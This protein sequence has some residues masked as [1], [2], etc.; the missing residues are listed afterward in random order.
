MPNQTQLNLS[1][2]KA[3]L[4]FIGRGND[5]PGTEVLP[6]LTGLAA[7]TIA[8]DKTLRGRVAQSRFTEILLRTLTTRF[9]VQNRAVDEQQ[10][11]RMISSA[12]R[13]QHL[14]IKDQT[15]YIP[16]HLESVPSDE[17]IELGPVTFHPLAAF[18]TTDRAQKKDVAAWI[19]QADLIAEITV[20][21]CEPVMSRRR[22]E[23]AVARARDMIRLLSAEA[24][25]MPVSPDA[26][27]SLPSWTMVTGAVPAGLLEQAGNSLRCLV[28]PDAVWPLAERFLDAVGWY[29]MAARE[30]AEAAAITLWVNALERLTMTR[31][32]ERITDCVARRTALL[33]MR[34][35]E[36]LGYEAGRTM[37][38]NLYMVRCGLVHGALRPFD[39]S[40]P[41]ERIEAERITRMSLLGSLAFFGEV[42]LLSTRTTIKKLEDAYDAMEKRLQSR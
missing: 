28:E 6:L 8:S 11:A 16:V 15:H 21:A 22:A 36:A 9:V 31:D 14:S 37:A 7:R 13:F 40:L 30:P 1:D 12:T 23:Q 19:G 29:A 25:L 4:S 20:P 33:V 35:D 10:V 34:A 39:A 41:G 27:H 42:G 2:V 17:T 38:D 3:A 26:A 5:K 18:A 24:S 32:H